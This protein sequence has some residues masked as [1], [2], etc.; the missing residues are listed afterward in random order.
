MTPNGIRFSAAV[1]IEKY[2][3]DAETMTELIARY[4]CNDGLP[5]IAR[6]W[7]LIA[8][9]IRLDGRD[10]GRLAGRVGDEPSSA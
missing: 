5:Q 3:S 8:A 9:T 4:F 2:G 7:Q 6:N 1:M 10:V